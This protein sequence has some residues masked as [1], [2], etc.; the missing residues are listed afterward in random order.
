[1]AIN[2]TN[3]VEVG[4]PTYNF[5]SVLS[6]LAWDGSTANFF[7]SEINANA[8]YTITNLAIGVAYMGRIKNTHATNAITITNPT[9]SNWILQRGLT[10]V[11]LLA[12]EEVSVSILFDGTNYRMAYGEAMI[13]NA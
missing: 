6:S 12:S 3:L 8:S 11:T 9:A 7:M 13:K 4:A 10:T 5:S 1:M 2:L